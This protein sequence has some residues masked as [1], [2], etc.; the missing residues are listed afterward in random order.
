MAVFGQEFKGADGGKGAAYRGVDVGAQGVKV[1]LADTGAFG[2]LG[3]RERG[4][5]LRDVF[6]PLFPVGLWIVHMSKLGH[7]LT[8]SGSAMGWAGL[9]SR[10]SPSV[11]PPERFRASGKHF[12]HPIYDAVVVCAR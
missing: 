2:K 9:V 5:R 4:V 3:V 12:A 11:D 8:K 7:F 10:V 6:V 1:A